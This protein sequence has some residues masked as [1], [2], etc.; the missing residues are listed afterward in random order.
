VYTRAYSASGA[1]RC[2]LNVYRAFETDAVTNRMRVEENGKSKV[3]CLSLWGGASWME[4][5]EAR[6]MAEE[7]YEDVEVGMVKG[8]GHWIAEEK[9][10]GFVDAVVVWI[11]KD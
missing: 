3:R 1:M 11:G 10:Q 8:A 9:P 7:F 2:A 6:G 4:T 5:K